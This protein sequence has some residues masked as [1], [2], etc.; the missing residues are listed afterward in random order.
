MVLIGAPNS[1]FIGVL[2][3]F[4]GP[5]SAPA[6]GNLTETFFLFACPLSGDGVPKEIRR[7]FGNILSQFDLLRA[8][9]R[10]GGLGEPGVPIGG[11][12]VPIGKSRVSNTFGGP[13]PNSFAGSG[14]SSSFGG[15]L[16][17]DDVLLLLPCDVDALVDFFRSLQSTLNQFYL[18]RTQE[19][20]CRSVT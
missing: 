14:S 16:R 13:G 11:P 7:I 4:L 18:V 19:E 9:T 8:F 6:E 3:I 1:S 17:S 20:F 12:G 2:P 15:S 5:S 10:P